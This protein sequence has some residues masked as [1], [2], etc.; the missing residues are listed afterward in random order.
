MRFHPAWA[1]FTGTAVMVGVGCGSVALGASHPVVS[2]SFGA[3]VTL[4]I[5]VVGG[6]SGAH[7]NP[8][9]SIAFWRDG[10]LEG[11]VLYTYIVAQASGATLAAWLLNGAAPTVP[12]PQVHLVNLVAIEVAITLALMLSILVVVDRTERRSVVAVAVGAA[13]ALLALVAG[14]ST[15]ASMNPARTIGPN[16]VAGHADLIPVYVL[17]TVIGAWIAVA[18]NQRWL[19]PKMLQD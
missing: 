19:R 12:A 18:V 10:K 14:P 1:E 13:V 17:S 16:L 4:V 2:L 3:A 5:L 15:G 9:V 7:I 6:W 11:D 8:A